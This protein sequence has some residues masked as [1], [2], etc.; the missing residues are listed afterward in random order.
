[1]DPNK[2]LIVLIL[3]IVVVLG[4]LMYIHSKGPTI[5]K[6]APWKPSLNVPGDTQVM[7]FGGFSDPRYLSSMRRVPFTDAERPPLIT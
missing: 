6:P 3:D 5:R 4:I 2:G 1:M 7:V